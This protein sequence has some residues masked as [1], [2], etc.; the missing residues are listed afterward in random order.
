VTENVDINEVLKFGDDTSIDLKKDNIVLKDVE[1]SENE[2]ARHIY[3][4]KLTTS[5]KLS[6]EEIDRIEDAKDKDKVIDEMLSND[7]SILEIKDEEKVRDIDLYIVVPLAFN[8]DFIVYDYP[9]YT[10]LKSEIDNE[11]EDTIENL[12][13][14]LKE[15]KDSDQEANMEAFLETF[16][17]SFSN[18]TEDKLSYILEDEKYKNGLNETLMFSEIKEL[19]IYE[20]ND[21]DLVVDVDVKFIHEQTNIETVSNYVL[22]VK[23]KEQRYVVKHVNNDQYL[24]ELIYGV[25][26]TEDESEKTEENSNET[27]V[28]DEEDNTE[29]DT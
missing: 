21:S 6:S 1:E 20:G 10:Y 9:S 4:I 14:E 2:K 29:E 24:Y 17:T 22:V 5:T 19:N 25:Q 28:D 11:E 18:D 16:F 23:E 13:D 8:K 7:E 15:V 3:K 12:L 26:E 27:D